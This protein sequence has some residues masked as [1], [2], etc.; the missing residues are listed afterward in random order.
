MK[1]KPLLVGDKSVGI[2]ELVIIVVVVAGVELTNN[3][4]NMKGCIAQDCNI[5]LYN[6]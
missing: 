2:G 6:T 4:T 3:K 1:N 5:S